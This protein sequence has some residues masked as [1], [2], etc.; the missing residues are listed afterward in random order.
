MCF[1]EK[2]VPLLSIFKYWQYTF[3]GFLNY[4]NFYVLVMLE[5][6]IFIQSILLKPSSRGK[7]LMDDPGEKRL[8]VSVVE[9]EFLEKG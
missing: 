9:L 5:T 1:P 2:S 8:D 6:T 4:F 7:K 3:L